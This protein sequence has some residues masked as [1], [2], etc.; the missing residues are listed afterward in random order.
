MQAPFGTTVLPFGTA[1]AVPNGNTL[2]IWHYNVV[3][4]WHY[5]ECL[6]RAHAPRIKDCGRPNLTIKRMKRHN[7]GLKSI[8]LRHAFRLVG[9]TDGA[10]I[11]QFEEPTGLTFRG[12]AP[13][14]LEDDCAS[15]PV[16][17]NNRANLAYFA[18]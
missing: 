11:A 2:Y 10:F 18:V 13:A 9:F 6:G 4:I 5:M 1:H 17:T 12:L 3:Y 16:S 7:C 8:T 15:K 14:L